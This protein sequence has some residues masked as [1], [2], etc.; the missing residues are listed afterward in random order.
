[1]PIS[2]IIPP[3][4]FPTWN[5]TWIDASANPYPLQLPPKYTVIYQSL[6]GAYA[7]PFIP[8]VEYR[9]LTPGAYLKYVNTDV[10][11]VELIML[12]QGID[13][14]DL[15]NNMSGW[16]Y[17]FSPLRPSVTP[18]IAAPPY[19][20]LQITTPNGT[21]RNLSCICIS[22]FNL[23]PASYYEQ[24]VQIPLHFYATSPYFFD[25]TPQLFSFN[26]FTSNK[27][28]V[29]P[30]L[31]LKLGLGGTINS[32]F[33]IPGPDGTYPVGDVPT[34]PYFYLTGPMST[35]S[36][37]NKTTNK[38]FNMT[39]TPPLVVGETLTID[40]KEKTVIRNL[41]TAAQMSLLNQVNINSQFWS[42]I[43]SGNV[44]ATTFSI[45]SGQPLETLINLTWY[46]QRM[47]VA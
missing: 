18:R 20:Y 35:F 14:N 47:G 7:P 16:P 37:T 36:T 33:N 41:G 3:S 11:D 17:I 24:S 6:V 26:P 42:L 40:M 25:A 2:Q 31:P 38:N 23:N 34:Y 8:V 15:W 5:F 43:P 12:V 44:V 32:Q 27:Y 29:F 9:P 30:A 28:L 4:L 22:D 21:I 1:M 39:I 10:R 45:A 46:P 19:P 13:P